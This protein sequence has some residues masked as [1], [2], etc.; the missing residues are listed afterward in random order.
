MGQV[1]EHLSD[2]KKWYLCRD[3]VPLLYMLVLEV[4]GGIMN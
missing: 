1:G 2:V 4:H 3:G